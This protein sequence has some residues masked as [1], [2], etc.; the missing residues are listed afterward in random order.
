MMNITLSE[1]KIRYP[2]LLL[3]HVMIAVN[4]H[5]VEPTYVIAPNDTVA[6]LRIKQTV[7]IG[8]SIPRNA[9]Y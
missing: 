7:P 1:L 5:F 2:A 8:R 4:E 9:H 3:D 6:L